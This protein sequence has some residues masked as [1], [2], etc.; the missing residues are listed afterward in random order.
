MVSPSYFTSI[1]SALGRSSHPLCKHSIIQQYCLLLHHIAV[2]DI[3]AAL[4]I[5]E[6][7]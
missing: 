2:K 3:K 4:I 1:L 6:R 5:P 7:S